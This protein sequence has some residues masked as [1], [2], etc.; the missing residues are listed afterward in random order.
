AKV[1]PRKRK[2]LPLLTPEYLQG[3]PTFTT[4]FF[5]ELYSRLKVPSLVVFDNYQE[6]PEESPLHEIMHTALSQIPEG[7][8]AIVMSRKD[9]PSAFIRLKA[10]QQIDFLRWESIRLTEEEAGEIV[11]RRAKEIC[12]PDTI[13]YLHSISDG[14]AAGLVLI[15]ESLK[16]DN[17]ELRFMR[18]RSFEEVFTYFARELFEKL[19]H[20]TQE[21][22]LYT[23]F[24]RKMTASMAE[25]IT[26]N[27]LAGDILSYMNHN[28]YF[29]TKHF[30]NE[31]VYE[32]HLLCR[33]FLM[34]HA[35]NMLPSETLSSIQCSA[36]VILERAGQTEAAVS[37]LK[38]VSDWEAM[39]GV[40]ISHAPDMIKQGRYEPL[41]EW[42]DS[43]PEEVIHGSPWLLYWK[44]ISVLP[45]APASAKSYLEQAFAGF[46]TGNDLIG[47]VLSAAGV[48]FAIYFLFDDF[49]T[50]GHW[51]N[52]LHD[53]A[54]K[55]DSFPNDEIEASV[56][57]SMIAAS[58]FENISHPKAETWEQRLLEI[59]ETPATINLKIHAFHLVFWHRLLYRSA[60]EALP[61]LS[62]LERLSRSRHAQPLHLIVLWCAE[63]QYYLITGLH[64][65][66]MQAADEGLKLSQN[67]GIDIHDKWFHVHALVSFL[68]RMNCKGAEK[69]IERMSSAEYMST[70][71]RS[72]YNVTLARLALIRG[73]LDQALYEG[74]Q[75][76]IITRNPLNVA[77]AHL[78]LSQVSHRM[79]NRE[80]ALQH[81]SQGRSYLAIQG[82][83]SQ[84]AIA[85]LI[86]AQFD[87]D[88]GNEEQGLQ[89]LREALTL[90]REGGYVFG[91]FDI[92]SETLR[93]CEKALEA[94]IEVEHVRTIIHRRGLIPEKP[95]VHIEEWPWALRIYTLGSF[96]LFRDDKP[97]EF[98]H[99][100]QQKPLA[101]L[102]AL[103]ALGGRNIGEERIAY[104]LWPD[105]DGDM[106]HHT[107]EMALHRL[108]KLLAYPDAVSF[109]NGKVTLDER[110][111]WVDAQAFE[112]LLVHADEYK[113]QGKAGH[114]S[115]YTEKAVKLYRGAFMAGEREEA[116]MAPLSERLKNKYFQSVW[117][118][119]HNLET[120]GH[121][122]RAAEYY[123]GCLEVDACMEEV[124]RRLMVCYKRL[125]RRGE[126]LSVYQRCRKTLSAVLGV[127]PS[128]ET[129]AIRNSIISGKP[130]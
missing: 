100:A 9:S 23:A 104:L 38:T 113:R 2:P 124:Y 107:F 29:I 31:P 79:G 17:T 116:W 28:N 89:L 13:H 72:L 125:G 35:R 68:N 3:I 105:A 61:L 40:I 62:L 1:A 130:S 112:R 42:L 22:L 95:P 53:L 88:E 81:L 67:C 36:A 83:R 57:A 84:L 80:E 32:Y 92:P 73:D 122:D 101:L 86:E 82:C 4:R 71:A 51:L 43:L 129:E 69:L 118:L 106:A 60:H 74:K 34:T 46:Q 110:Y 63:V 41:R 76:L 96:S 117:W 39:A 102:K 103:I 18:K 45:F 90:A 20:R 115:E 24:L 93:M 12:S 26:G 120:A 97:V 108:R 87:F 50:I 37:L 127:N 66:L 70:L 21:F 11:A 59:P 6:V 10:N 48:V 56:I 91:F 30:D 85:L 75:G 94:G 65:E 27:P 99:K 126:A 25:E 15:Y 14:W 121:W 52:I 114:A 16:R 111:C 77:I 55:I 19:D 58:L 109:R 119:G 123:E 5:E 8:N 49:T 54:A 33:D 64:Y 7:I 78:M 98:S 47:A 44:G 128:P